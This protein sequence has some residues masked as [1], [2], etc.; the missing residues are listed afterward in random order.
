MLKPYNLFQKKEIENAATFVLEKNYIHDIHSEIL[1]KGL[2][3][4]FDVSFENMLQKN[5]F[6]KYLIKNNSKGLSYDDFKENFQLMNE[7]LEFIKKTLK[8][9]KPKEIRQKHFEERWLLATSI[10]VFIEKNG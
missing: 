10:G 1:G 2:G 6:M 7:D 3:D 8:S 5:P 4:I 9:D